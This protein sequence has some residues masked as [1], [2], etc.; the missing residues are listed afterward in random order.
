MQTAKLFFLLLVASLAV[1]V[2]VV[3]AGT[4]VPQGPFVRPRSYGDHFGAFTL[5]GGPA[6]FGGNRYPAQSNSFIDE[7]PKS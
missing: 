4:T 5:C 3:E 7:W 2:A 1:L 6:L